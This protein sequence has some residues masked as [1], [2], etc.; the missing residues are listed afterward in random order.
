MSWQCFG[1]S[2]GYC[3][4]GRRY[5]TS[6]D[7]GICIE[8]HDQDYDPQAFPFKFCFVV[9]NQPSSS[10]LGR[11]LIGSVAGIEYYRQPMSNS[12]TW[13]Q[14]TTTVNFEHE[15]GRY[16]FELQ[17]NNGRVLCSKTVC[18]GEQIEEPIVIDDPVESDIDYDRIVEGNAL[19]VNA[20]R[21]ETVNE[22][23]ENQGLIEGAQDSINSMNEG[24]SGQISSLSGDIKSDVGGLS[25]KI[26]SRM[27]EGLKVVRDGLLGLSGKISSIQI[28]NIADIK[29]AFMDVCADLAAAL[30][31]AILDKIE[32]R[33][34]DDEKERD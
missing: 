13:A 19:I 11:V 7:D 4:T 18:I 31:D 9:L 15:S 2:G 22:V 26:D 21:D 30:W 8:D 27:D 29:Y 33:Y 32:E 14:L 3:H 24:L 12:W 6:A 17:D 25:Q 34:P 16:E 28:P 1:W 5:F 20:A 10:R 23:N